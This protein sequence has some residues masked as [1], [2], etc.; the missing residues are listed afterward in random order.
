MKQYEYKSINKPLRSEEELLKII[1]ELGK[2]GWRM[3]GYSY[4]GHIFMVREI[5]EDV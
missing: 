3:C 5:L 4:P 1:N 2:K